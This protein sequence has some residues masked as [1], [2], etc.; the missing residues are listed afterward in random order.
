M[1]Y[2]LFTYIYIILFFFFLNVSLARGCPA[3]VLRMWYSSSSTPLE[4]CGVKNGDSKWSFLSEDNNM[5][6][7]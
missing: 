7:R 2:C 3:A 1:L 6:L 5:R 4:L